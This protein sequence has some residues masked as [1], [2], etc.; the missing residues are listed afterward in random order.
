MDIDELQRIIL[1]GGF[2]MTID[3]SV[4]QQ[5]NPSNEELLRCGI[6]EDESLA[7]VLCKACGHYSKCVG[8]AMK[9]LS[10]LLSESQQSE[11]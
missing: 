3:F 11:R 8:L 7:F 6:R 9:N 4:F 2:D 5:D 1:N 10:K